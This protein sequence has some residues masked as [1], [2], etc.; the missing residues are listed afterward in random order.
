MKSLNRLDTTYKEL[1][2]VNKGTLL[3][4][5]NARLDTTY[6]ELKPSTNRAKGTRKEK[7]RY[8]L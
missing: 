6:K 5:V 3:V 8:Y 2:L 1:K 7:I 4:P